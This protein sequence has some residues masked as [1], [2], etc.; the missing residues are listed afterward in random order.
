MKWET[1]L[2]QSQAPA[3]LGDSAVTRQGRYS[4]IAE[5]GRVEF[6]RN[7]RNKADWLQCALRQITLLQMRGI[8]VDDGCTPLAPPLAAQM[9]GQLRAG[10]KE[11]NVI[12]QAGFGCL[13]S[14]GEQG[15]GSEHRGEHLGYQALTFWAGF[16]VG[17]DAALELENSFDG[18]ALALK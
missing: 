11:I 7:L 9:P 17:I 13:G 15:A 3:R 10:F 5:E 16:R 6:A 4:V 8:P 2:L 12:N 1:G 18:F 14:L